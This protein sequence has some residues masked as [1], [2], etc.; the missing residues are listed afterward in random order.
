MPQIGTYKRV[1]PRVRVLRGFNPQEPFTLSQGAPVASGVTIL[2]GQVISLAWNAAASQYEWVLG[3]P[4][5]AVGAT[6]YISLNDSIDYDVVEAGK[7]PGL[8][9]AG[10]F[11]IQTPHFK[12]ADA[13]GFVVDAPVTYD[14]ETGNIKLWVAPVEGVA[15]APIIGFVTRHNGPVT[16]SS[17]GSGSPATGGNNGVDSSALSPIQVVTFTTNLQTHVGIQVDADHGS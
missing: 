5:A 1:K 11:E 7:L 6:P 3:V 12:S 2:S 9:S 15:G 16:L 4:A 17:V 13:N 8:S 10:Q 14:G